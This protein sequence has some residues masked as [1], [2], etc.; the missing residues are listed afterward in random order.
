[1][2]V[3]SRVAPTELQFLATHP[4]PEVARLATIGDRL[5]TLECE[6]NDSLVACR[7][8]RIEYCEQTSRA[9]EQAAQ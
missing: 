6:L 7:T 3:R 1:M 8:L 4:N 5:F 2:T 9:L